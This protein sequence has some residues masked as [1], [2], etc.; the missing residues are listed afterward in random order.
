MKIQIK[1]LF[2][3]ILALLFIQSLSARTVDRIV[4][5]VNEE[6]ITQSDIDAVFTTIEPEFR[7]VYSDPEELNRKLEQVKK[8]IINQLVEEKLVLSEA[9][10]HD[11]QIDKE[12]VEERIERLKKRFSS[13]KEFELALEARS[14][15]LKDLQDIFRNQEIKKRTVDYFVRSEIKVDPIEI[16]QFYQEHQE[17]FIRPEK[18]RVLSILIGIDEN[19]DEDLAL[20][21]AE[22]ILERLKKGEDFAELSRLYSQGASAA[23]GG[24]LGFVERG[25]F[26]KEIDE[27]IFS[28]RPGEFTDVIKT[29]KGWRIF[30]VEEKIP[31]QIIPFSEAQE[32]I[33]QILY[34]K[35][36]TKK[37]KQWIKKL[38]ESAYIVIKEGT[39]DEKD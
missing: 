36:F 31:R 22:A 38:K 39:P 30:K 29:D 9:K 10:R 2:I 24:N 17:E 12:I 33:R 27:A 6:I 4:A 8:N 28:L 7:D 19:L 16:R 5:I 15:T 23:E 18:A 14:L 34:E 35:K 32:V 21:K 37:F 13:E 1:T 11:I 3:P 20:Q 25:Q 26:I